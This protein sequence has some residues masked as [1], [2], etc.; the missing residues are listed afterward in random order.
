M[1]HLS[2]LDQ[3]KFVLALVQFVD[4]KGHV[5]VRGFV[6]GHPDS[7]TVTTH[8]C[9]WAPYLVVIAPGPFERHHS[10]CARL[11]GHTL[12]LDPALGVAAQGS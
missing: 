8:R 11:Q 7:A 5:G 2:Y 4:L 10:G 6:P 1:P 3:L 12:R 9:Q